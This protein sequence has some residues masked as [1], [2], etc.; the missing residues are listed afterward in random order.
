MAAQRSFIAF[1]CFALGAALTAAAAEPFTVQDLVR[2]E[3]VSELAASP[4]GKHLAY[5][6][7]T[8]DMEAN[9]G[10]TA[11]WLA[12]TGARTRHAAAVRLTDIAAKCG[13]WLPPLRRAP[14]RWAA[15]RSRSRTC[16][17]MWAA[18]A[19]RPRAIASS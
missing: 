10:R 1:A 6:L 12:D 14:P 13:E 2:L 9:K 17:S 4:D 11:I 18:F 3:R 7:R 8:T 16:R 15:H 5:T 19:S